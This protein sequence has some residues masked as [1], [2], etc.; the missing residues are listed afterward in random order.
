MIFLLERLHDCLC[1]EKLHFVDMLHNF[2]VERLRDFFTHSPIPSLFYRGCM[3][4]CC[5]EVV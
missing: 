1:V 3:I 4:F 5:G 2:C